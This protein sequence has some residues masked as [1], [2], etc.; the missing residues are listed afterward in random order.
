MLVRMLFDHDKMK[1]T[2]AGIVETARKSAGLSQIQLAERIGVIQSTISRIEK[3]VLAPTLY[4][5][6]E[7]CRVLDIPEDA[8]VIGYYDRGS[9][10]K[11]NSDAKE[12]GFTLPKTYRKNKCIKVRHMLPLFNFVKNEIGDKTFKNILS[13]LKMKTPFFFNL[14]NQVNIPFVNDFIA[15]LEKYHKIDRRNQGR[16]MKYASSFA[17]HG[18]LG[19][20]FRNAQNQ[21]DLMDRYLTNAAKYQRLFSIENYLYTGNEITFSVEFNPALK[22]DLLS[23]G[24]ERES[25]LWSFYV[26]YLKKFSLFDFKSKLQK[27]SE[28]II[29]FTEANANFS[30]NVIISAA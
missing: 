8:I 24:P 21:L 15:T 22:K 5:W 6:L 17:S 30:R 11:L 29:Q 12:G 10:T 19:K 25:F 26:N 7:M 23:T 1:L 16:I 3:G 28:V 4:H 9:V 14:D 13:D 27:T 20:L 18:V 2:A